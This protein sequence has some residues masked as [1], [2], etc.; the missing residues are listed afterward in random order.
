MSLSERKESGYHGSG[1]A[2]GNN[3]GR[4]FRILLRK[5][6]PSLLKIVLLNDR[7]NI[8]AGWEFIHI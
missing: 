7:K 3:L 6:R 1:A 4:Y 5:N 8:W 2:H